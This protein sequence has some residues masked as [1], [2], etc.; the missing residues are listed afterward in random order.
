[1]AEQLLGTLDRE[2]VLTLVTSDGKEESYEK[3]F[4]ELNPTLKYVMEDV[5][6]DNENGDKLDVSIFPSDNILPQ[7]LDFGNLK[8]IEKWCEHYHNTSLS[9]NT[10][11]ISQ[12]EKLKTLDVMDKWH[13][14]DSWEVDFVDKMIHIGSTQ[15]P[16]YE[17]FMKVFALSDYLG[18]Q[19]FCHVL[20]DRW[21]NHLSLHQ[22]LNPEVLQSKLNIKGY[23]PLDR[24]YQWKKYNWE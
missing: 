12:E 16:P 18:N 19:R 20:T 7:C 10:N 15:N 8:I 4:L 13:T 3:W 17:L 9:R 14:A 24:D 5:G 1:M 23:L 2:Y 22:M 21:I 11:S 6:I